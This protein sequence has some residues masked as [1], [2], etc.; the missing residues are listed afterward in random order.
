MLQAPGTGA[1]IPGV[2]GVGLELTVVGGERTLTPGDEQTSDPLP[3]HDA[4]A[5]YHDSAV[6]H[7]E[8]VDGNLFAVD[9]CPL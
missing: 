1:A 9:V 2:M 6:L 4:L 8:R 5:D 7:A 3:A